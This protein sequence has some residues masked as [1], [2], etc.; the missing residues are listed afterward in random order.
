MHKEDRILDSENQL[1]KSHAK[2]NSCLLIAAIIIVLLA[3]FAYVTTK[4]ILNAFEIVDRGLAESNRS[5]ENTNEALKD[6]LLKNSEHSELVERIERIS[7][8]YN[9]FMDST[10]HLLVSQTGGWQQGSNQKELVNPRNRIVPT[11][12]LVANGLG[13]KIEQSI[14]K[15]SAQ[16]NEIINVNLGIDTI[17]VPLKI[18]IDHRKQSSETWAEYNFDQMPLQAVLPILRKFKNDEKESKLIIYQLL[19]D[20]E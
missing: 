2:R 1:N 19:V 10:I 8:E 18:Q 9:A 7:L 3:I 20:D 11:R 6:V 15:T 5:Y 14:T 16:Y 12:I 13:N 17:Q 4:E